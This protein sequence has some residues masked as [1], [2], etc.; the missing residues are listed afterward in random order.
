M[1]E[2]S[3]IEPERVAGEPSSDDEMVPIAFAPDPIGAH[4]LCALLNA[5][6]VDA[7]VV[8]EHTAGY[9]PLGGNASVSVQ[10][11][12]RDYAGAVAA[13]DEFLS[14]RARDPSTPQAQRCLVCDYDLR[15]L[16]PAGDVVCPECGIN[17]V[18]TSRVWKWVQLA[19]PPQNARRG[20]DQTVQSIGVALGRIVLLGL[21]G[22]VLA[23]VASLAVSIW[24]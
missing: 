7:T 1:S 13:L 10:V 16:E 20:A 12:Q 17:A 5:R 21:I 4:L 3:P 9:G 18:A 11:R 14:E 19:Q 23:M 8:G 24:R 6:D 15:G 2:R 22:A